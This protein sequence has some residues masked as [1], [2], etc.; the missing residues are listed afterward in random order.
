MAILTPVNITH[1]NPELPTVYFSDVKGNVWT[2]GS[3]NEQYGIPEGKRE[4]GMIVYFSSSQDFKYYKGGT[5][6]SGDWGTAA[7]WEVLGGGQT[8]SQGPGIII[9]GSNYISASIGAGLRF[10][11][12]SKIEAT[13]RTVNG[14]TPDTITG[15]ITTALTAVL[16]GPSASDQ[17][18]GNNLVLSS[19]GAATGSIT[20][21]TIWVVSGDNSSPDPDGLAYIFVSQSAT[22]GGYGEW[23]PLST[24][25]Q[26][27]ADLRYVRLNVGASN[28]QNITSSLTITGSY[29]TFSSSLYWPIT[30][31]MTGGGTV[32]T[33]IW[34]PSDGQI[35]TTGSYGGG[36]GSTPSALTFGTQITNYA[37]SAS[38]NNKVVR[39]NSSTNLE[40]YVTASLFSSGDQVIVFQSG[41]GQVTFIPDSSTEML[42]ANNMRKLRTQYS[43]AT[44]TFTG[45]TCYL[46]GDI[47]P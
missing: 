24:L 8:Y 46:F 7:N 30:Q 5:T 45:N 17:G 43:A 10:D 11:N 42:S 28:N 34:D 13:V 14:A 40:V 44:L 6:S 12:D 39:M 15:N 4:L 19:S 26:S 22:A 21:A 36:G 25:N 37:L 31:S 38:D 2:T 9:D 29:V 35:K 18:G 23:F 41:S 47:A 33:L 1:N 20:N 32:N 3:Y 27:Q 16:T